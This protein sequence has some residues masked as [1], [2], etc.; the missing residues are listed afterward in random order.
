MDEG[1]GATTRI[2]VAAVTDLPAA[3]GGVIT[4]NAG[5]V[6]SFIADIDLGTDRLSTAGDAVIEGHGQGFFSLQTSHASPLLASTHSVDVRNM[7]FINDLGP[8]LAVG[9]VGKNVDID[10]CKFCSGGQDTFTDGFNLNI[11]N[12]EW[13][14]PGTFGLRVAGT[15]SCV[16]LRGLGFFVLGANT[17]IEFDSATVAVIV[18]IHS[19][20]FMGSGTETFFQID[21]AFLPS[22]RGGI[23]HVFWNGVGTLWGVGSIDQSTPGWRISESS[24]FAD[25][26]SVGSIRFD[27]NQ[28][29]TTIATV[30]VYVDINSLPAMSLDA[31]SERFSLING[32]EM[33]YLGVDPLRAVVMYD[34]HVE[35]AFNNKIYEIQLLK[36]TVEQATVMVDYR[37]TPTQFSDMKIVFL[38]TNDILTLKVRNITDDTNVTIEHAQIVAFKAAG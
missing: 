23:E 28:T 27:A 30:D 8:C 17:A 29:A 22:V 20:Q 1:A 21:T 35:G 34:G 24:G 11:R 15:W 9:G 13:K 38:V 32:D 10:F 3:S 31:A 2:I 6:Y 18:E 19:C 36:N 5:V 7:S 26:Q 14:T 4:L 16:L 37:S 12:S 25:S 33:Q